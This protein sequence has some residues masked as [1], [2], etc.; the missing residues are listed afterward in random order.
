MHIVRL[1]CGI[2]AQVARH[3]AIEPYVFFGCV[4]HRGGTRVLEDLEPAF[5]LPDGS[6][7][8]DRREHDLDIPADALTAILASEKLPKAH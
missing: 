5:W 1:R 3:Y 8:D 7:C 4:V 6:F 2:V